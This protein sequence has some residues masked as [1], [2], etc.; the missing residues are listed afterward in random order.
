MRE[1][2]WY[3]FSVGGLTAAILVGALWLHS[4]PQSRRARRYVLWV[5]LLYAVLT[6][7]AI[8]DGVGR[9]L[10]AGLSPLQAHDVPS[11]AT[12]IVVLG[13]SGFTARDWADGRYSIVDRVDA[14][15]AV[16]AARVFRLVDAEWVVA[17]GGKPPESPNE[18]S[19]NTLRGALVSLGVPAARIVVETQSRDTHDEAVV[20]APMLRTLNVR[21]VVLV[22]SGTHMRRSLGTFRAQGI[23]A[24]PAVARDPFFATSWTHW[25]F[26]SDLGLWKS[27]SV[28]H[29]ILGFAYYVVRGWYAFS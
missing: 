17:S 12:A 23:R 28:M 10:G 4:A 22:T 29:E 7:Y 8:G 13:S 9:L 26:P 24:I 19:G 3:F 21:H 2:I 20:L 11:G 1:L 5:A 14:T 18:A 16:E 27:A 15:R 25:I 6:T